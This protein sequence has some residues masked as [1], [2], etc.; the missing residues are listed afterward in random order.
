MLSALSN[1]PISSLIVMGFL[2]ALASLVIGAGSN[3]ILRDIGCGT[4]VNGVLV[5]VG[6]IFGVWTRYLI[7]GSA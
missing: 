2:T 3:M 6:A 1:L 4:F 5:V 7:F